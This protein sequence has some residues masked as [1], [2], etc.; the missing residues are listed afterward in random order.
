M[1]AAPALQPQPP[2]RTGLWMPGHF[3]TQNG[4]KLAIVN[5]NPDTIEVVEVADEAITKAMGH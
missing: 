2:R 1:S 4:A 3:I 5:L